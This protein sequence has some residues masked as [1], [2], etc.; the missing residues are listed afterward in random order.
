M[1]SGEAKRDKETSDAEIP[2]ASKFPFKDMGA[3]AM[4]RR[5]TPLQAKYAKQLQGAH[6]RMLNEELYTT[7]SSAAV[8][9]FKKV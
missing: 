6:F 5:L 2:A 9:M 4:D 8:A 1:V 3:V 7:P